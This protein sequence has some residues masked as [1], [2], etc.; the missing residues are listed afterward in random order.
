[1]KGL[2]GESAWPSNRRGEINN[3]TGNRHARSR[4]LEEIA[5][6]VG[7]SHSMLGFADCAEDCGFYSKCRVKL[8]FH[9]LN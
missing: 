7:R 5:G 1:M 4:V 2:R 3:I 6:M 9:I 8:V